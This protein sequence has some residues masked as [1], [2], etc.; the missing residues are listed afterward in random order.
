VYYGKESGNYSGFKKIPGEAIESVVISDL[1]VGETYYFTVT[2]YY[3][4]GAE[5]EYAGERI[6][7]IKDETPPASPQNILLN[8]WCDGEADISWT[9]N[10]DDAV[11]YRV[12]YGVSSG[13]YGGSQD[14]K[15]ATNI[16]LTGLAGGNIYY[17]AVKAYDAF[18]NESLNPN[19]LTFVSS[20]SCDGMVAYWPFDNVLAGVTPD[21]AGNNDGTLGGG[22][23]WDSNG[24]I[25]GAINFNGS[26]GYVSI[27]D[28]NIL[29]VT[30]TF[31]VS[32]WF[33]RG[34]TGKNEDLYSKNGPQ[35]TGALTLAITPG[36]KLNAIVQMK[37]VVLIANTP[38]TDQNWHHVALT[39]GSDNFWVIYLDG[40][41]DGRAEDDVNIPIANDRPVN[42]GG[43]FPPTQWPP[44]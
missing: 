10:S 35:I 26:D 5:S 7:E 9:A 3:N 39:R 1:T 12:Y 2:S 4:T 44:V 8:K 40:K 14:V 25:G 29:D 6:V 23:S 11:G 16:I 34:R 41:E 30:T 31:S 15:D 32:M 33:K 24:R 13:I 36:N 21:N 18:G 19:E 27:A 37:K 43:E 22:A 17:A 38:I 42:I 20:I 28:N